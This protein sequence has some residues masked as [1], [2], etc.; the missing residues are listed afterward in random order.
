MVALEEYYNELIKTLED[1]SKMENDH[2]ENIIN[3]EF[4][5]YKEIILEFEK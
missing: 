1:F 2:N 5:K 4:K 3:G